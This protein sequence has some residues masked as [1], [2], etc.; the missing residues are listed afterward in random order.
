VFTDVF[1]V[2]SLYGTFNG[3][4][5]GDASGLVVSFDN[6]VSGYEEMQ[7]NQPTD[8]TIMC[9]PSGYGSPPDGYVI[10][11]VYAE[12]GYLSLGMCG[13]V[14]GNINYNAFQIKHP[15]DGLTIC[16]PFVGISIPPGYVQTAQFS[17]AQ[18]GPPNILWGFNAVQIAVAPQTSTPGVTTTSMIASGSGALRVR[19]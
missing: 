5:C 2:G 9:L 4:P 10:T 18:C 1:S 7:I 8:G 6:Y 14:F 11:G 19:R 15:S 12:G 13:I 17:T 16:E 3:G